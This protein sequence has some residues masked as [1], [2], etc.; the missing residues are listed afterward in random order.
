[1]SSTQPAEPTSTAGQTSTADPGSI[2]AVIE[3]SSLP[4]GLPD[5]AAISD[6]AF[7]PA[8]TQAIAEHLAEVDQIAADPEPPTFA[9]TVEA[10]ELSGQKLARA[11]RI[12]SNLAISDANPQRDAIA[13]DLA[14]ALAEHT[15]T[16]NLDPRL[17][18]RIHSLYERR[19]E[20]GLT[21]TQLRL[22]DKQHRDAIR[23]GAGLD[24]SAQEEMR[25]ISA[26]LA[27]LA[28]KFPQNVLAEAYT[29][30]VL[31]TDEAE[32]D[33]LSATAVA[34]ARQAAVEAGHDQG[35]LIA[36]EL[37]SSQSAVAEL[38]DPAVRRR[39]FEA[40]VTRC[41]H[42]EH[43]NR[44]LITEII[45]LRARR[46][47]LLGYAD[48]AA[49]EIAEQTAPSPAAVDE[50][51]TRLGAAAVRAGERELQQVQDYADSVSPGTVI[52]AS[53]YT[54]W[55]ERQ[56]GSVTGV[57]LD[58]FEEYCELERVLTHGIFFAAGQLYGLQFVE[59][60]DLVGYHPDVRVWEVFDTAGDSIALF[61]GDFHARS[62]K[63]GGAWMSTFV[64]QSSVLAETPVVVNVLNL[65]K[66]EPGQPSLLSVDN[67]I[68]LFHEFGHSVHGLLSSVEYP[69]QSG[70]SVPPDFVEFP[71]QV[72]EMWAFHPEVLANYAVHHRTGEPISPELARAAREAVEVESA[73]S[74]IEYLA[75][76]VL[77]LAWHRLGTEEIAAVED[78]EAFEAAALA[79]AG[80]AHP[81]IPPRYRSTYFNHIFGGQYAASY[82][83]YIWSEVLAAETEQWF[84]ANGGLQVE[85]GR[86]FAEST[87]SRGD[88]VD[89]LAAHQRLIGRK[90]ELGPLLR[91][92]GLEPVA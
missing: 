51:L 5:F 87:L 33:G 10:L 50:L 34:A 72:N 75:A 13:R 86:R 37:P 62:S 22:L 19:D 8:F 43:D 64:D 71:S 44:A 9:N 12:F 56:R 25:T 82:Y 31:I 40:S 78:V 91:K 61:L 47:E 38:T 85:S 35:W 4:H 45:A 27:W 42:G 77:D 63:R 69:S 32:L 67:L 83:S 1:M 79:T 65:N 28:T 7:R 89:P 66:P 76:A 24:A 16:I 60:D 92:R 11:G 41:L 74:T 57:D 18:S 88:S 26:R 6:D 49:Y 15:D 17:F 84:L 46:A 70:A 14:V 58:R 59:R 80:L 20:L 39:V 48:A 90:P 29:A 68:T 53:D 54:Y 81:L 3:R 52:A 73:H 55:L 23:A 2:R 30:G 36:M 21:E